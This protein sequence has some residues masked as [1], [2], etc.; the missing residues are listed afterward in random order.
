[1]SERPDKQPLPKQNGMLRPSGGF[2][3]LRSFQMAEIV[4]DA[5]VS[6]CDRHRDELS[7][8]YRDQMVQAARSGRQNIAEGSCA[9]ATSA[10]SEVLLTNVARGSLEELLLDYEDYLR[11]HDLSQWDK[12]SVEARAVRDVC[13]TR[14]TDIAHYAEWFQHKDNVVVVNALIC[15]CNQAIYLLKRQVQALEARHLEMGGYSEQLYAERV[16]RREAQQ[17]VS[18]T[19]DCPDCGK[20]M[21]QRKARRGEHAGKAFW[22]CSGFPECRGTRKIAGEERDG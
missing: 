14:G 12:D 21:V 15:V 22:G 13:T 16:A 19:P 4:F 2:R 3:S 18:Q 6:F 17:T 11:H 5:T 8:R 7:P 10:K 9:S 20:P 1:M